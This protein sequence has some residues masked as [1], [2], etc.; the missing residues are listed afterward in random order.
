M[1]VFVVGGERFVGAGRGRGRGRG[2]NVRRLDPYL[3]RSHVTFH[4]FVVKKPLLTY[5]TVDEFFA[6]FVH[7]VLYL[8]VTRKSLI[9]A[10]NTHVGVG[11]CRRRRGHLEHLIAD[12]TLL[13]EQF[14]A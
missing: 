3:M 11:V 5:R 13:C 6:F 14:I 1:F 2:N 7:A 10:E 8:H 9:Q 4:L 12:K